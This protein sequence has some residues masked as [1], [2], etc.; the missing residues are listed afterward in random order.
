MGL[1]KKQPTRFPD[2][3]AVVV[4]CL[5]LQCRPWFFSSSST[6][7]VVLGRLLRGRVTHRFFSVSGIVVP[8]TLSCQ[9]EKYHEPPCPHPM[10]VPV[11]SHSSWSFLF[12]FFAWSTQRDIGP[13]LQHGQMYHLRILSCFPFPGVVPSPSSFLAAPESSSH[14][15]KVYCF[16]VRL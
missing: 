11:L 12:F 1:R 2:K 8:T 15:P 14:V 4:N 3:G 6:P 9:V 7:T 10:L 16:S 5:W 13:P